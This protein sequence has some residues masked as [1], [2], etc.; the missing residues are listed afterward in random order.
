M[1][2]RP[3]DSDQQYYRANEPT[4]SPQPKDADY[5]SHNQVMSSSI[6][7]VNRG[8]NTG[9]RYLI[10]SNVLNPVITARTYKRA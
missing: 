6:T 9:I 2:A 10:F 1:L 8:G 5:K 4:Q 7:M 3:D